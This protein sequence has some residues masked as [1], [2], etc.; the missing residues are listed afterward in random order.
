MAALRPSPWTRLLLAALLS[1]SFPGEMGESGTPLQQ[2]SGHGHPFQGCLPPDTHLATQRT[3][4]AHF[5]GWGAV[6]LSH[7]AQNTEGG[8]LALEEREDAHSEN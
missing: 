6:S 4:T 5:E 1:V 3:T 2:P 7:A 8:R